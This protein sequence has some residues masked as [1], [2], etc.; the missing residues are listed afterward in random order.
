[1]IDEIAKSH[2]DAVFETR[3]P[4]GFGVWRTLLIDPETS[5]TY[6]V[7]LDEL[8]DKRISRK[9]VDDDGRYTVQFVADH[10]A[11]DA[12]P[13]YLDKALDVLNDD[14]GVR[15]DQIITDEEDHVESEELKERRAE[16]NKIGVDTLREG[17]SLKDGTTFGP[18][19]K[20]RDIVDAILTDEGF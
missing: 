17:Y 18:S 12:T 15:V 16:L 5:E 14:S 13:F 10:R 2:E 1:M 4:D 8:I 19:D 9:D 6:T 11:D 20:K 3:D 7:L